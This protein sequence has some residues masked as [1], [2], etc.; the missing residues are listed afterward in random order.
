MHDP[1]AGRNP[2]AGGFF[3]HVKTTLRHIAASA[4]V[5]VLLSAFATGQTPIGTKIDN[6]GTAKFSY[7]GGRNDSAAT[8]VASVTVAGHIGFTL[9]KS[10]SPASAVP[11]DT[12]VYTLVVADTGTAPVGH[13]SVADTLPASLA[14]AGTTA[15]TVSGQVVRWNVPTLAPGGK[16]TL[17]I[18]AALQSNLPAGSVVTNT[19]YG[20]DSTGK[21]VVSQALFAVS[22]LPRLDVRKSVS[23]SSVNGGDTLT[24]LVTLVNSGN[25]TITRVTANDTLPAV[26]VFSSVSPNAS[27]SG[28]V[29]TAAFDS[30]SQGS[31]DTVRITAIVKSNLTG[32][33][34]ILNSARVTS[35]QLPQL[36]GSASS[37]VVPRPAISITKT[38]L[39]DSAKYGDTVR[40][41]ISY[42]NSGNV[43][44]TN[45]T[46]TDS[47]LPG[48]SFLSGSPSG[49]LKN[50]SFLVLRDSL[51][52]GQSDS[53][54][55]STKVVSYKIGGGI[56]RN[57]AT[58][59]SDQTLL[60]SAQAIVTV[61]AV[62]GFMISKSS[63]RDS[64]VI[65]D[66]VRYTIALRNT[67]TIPLT[68]FTMT[69]TLPAMLTDARTVPAGLLNGNFVRFGAD[70]LLP[71]G[72][73]TIMVSARIAFGIPAGSQIV[74]RAWGVAAEAPAKSSEATVTAKASPAA[75]SCRMTLQVNPA[76]VRGDGA[77]TAVITAIYTDSAG[78]PKPDGTLVQFIANGGSF[79]DGRDTSV[80]PLLGGI[81]TDSLKLLVTG[82]MP[83][84]VRITA[85]AADSALCYAAD[86]A[87]AIFYP[88][89][90]AGIVVDHATGQP[91][92]GAIVSVLNPA[93]SVV[94][95]QKTA[96]A[97]S[98]LIP[99]P[100]SGVY[101]VQTVAR[102]QFNQSVAVVD[103]GLTV[104]LSS[105][106]AK[107]PVQAFNSASGR[108]FDGVSGL[109]LPKAGTRVVLTDAQ[110]HAALDSAVTDSTGLFFF[111]KISA[112]SF[113]AV[114][115]DGL[116]R[117]QTA[118]ANAGGGEYVV[119]VNIPL[120]T[121]AAV[122][123]TKTGPAKAYA[124]DT[125]IY[126]IHLAN[127]SRTKLTGVALADTLD[128]SMKYV[129]ATG[130][131]TFDMTGH[132][133]LWSIP[134]VDTMASADFAVTVAF[135]DS[136]PSGTSAINRVVMTGNEIEP[137]F[138]SAVTLVR[139]PARL[140][141]MKVVSVSKAVPGDTLSYLV[142]IV[143]VS[144]IRADSVVLTDKLPAQL[145]YV[146]SVPSASYDAV[147]GTV[148]WILDSLTAGSEI[149]FRVVGRVRSGLPA[150]AYT[151]TNVAQAGWQGG[152]TTSAQNPGSHADV[153]LLVPYLSIQK[154]AV[155]R[156]VE[157]GDAAIYTI[158]VTNISTSTTAYGVVIDDMIPLGCRYIAGSSYRDTVRIADPSGT[159]KLRWNLADSLPGGATITLTYRLV[160]GAGALDGNG[161]N[162]AQGS[163]RTA[164]GIV[165]SSNISQ[166]R[167]QINQGVFTDH[168]LVIGKVFYDDN[169]NREQ[170]PG[171][172]GVKGIELMTEDGTRI[173]TG[174]DGKYSLPDVK[175]GEHVI[176]V[177]KSSLPAGAA[178]MAGYGE[179]AQEPSSRFV[180][181][182]EG[183][184]ARVDF[185][186]RRA[187]P[188]PA[189][190]E[191]RVANIGAVRV[192]R[193]SSPGRII[194]VT[195]EAAAPVRLRGTQF[196]PGKAV[197]KEGAYATLK[198]VGDLAREF[199]RQT[200]AISGHTDSVRIHTREFPSN[201]ELSE[202]RAEAVKR[203]LVQVEKIDSTRISTI[204]FGETAP[205]APN[206]TKNGR[207][208][209]RRVEISMSEPDKE[210]D[211][212]LR[213]VDVSL[214]VHYSGAVPLER[215]ELTDEFDTLLHFVQGSGR[216]GSVPAVPRTEGGKLLWT[217]PA[218]GTSFDAVLSYRLSVTIPSVAEVRA[219]V[220]TRVSVV[221]RTG[222]PIDAGTLATVTVAGRK[223][224]LKPMNFSL[225][226][227]LFEAGSASMKPQAAAALRDAA[228]VLMKYP[229]A[230]VNVDG[231]TDAKPVKN[232]AF[233]SNVALADARAKSV[234]DTLTGRYG[235]AARRISTF[236]WGELK[237][238][239][240]NATEEGR[241]ANRRVEI[242]IYRS[243][244]SADS[245]TV[246]TVDSSAAVEAVV[247]AGDGV[248]S[249]T[250][251]AGEAGKELLVEV[252]VRRSGER[253]PAPGMITDSL[254]PEMTVAASSFHAVRGI[255]SWQ[256]GASVISVKFRQNDSVAVYR[257]KAGVGSGPL[258][259][260]PVHTVTL[261]RMSA[262]GSVF[263][264]RRILSFIKP[265]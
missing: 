222:S 77:A 105:P 6:R 262:S 121:T 13:A 250:C 181:V 97:G 3:N 65:G 22:A 76:V 90:I 202:A 61:N 158:K 62:P 9:K 57:V 106:G 36:A 91:V 4:V 45:V 88:G 150:G 225:P 125:V 132:R 58:I 216:I 204:G 189:A 214:P 120:T 11:G 233:A 240:S 138:A 149:S 207:A 248:L 23:K 104:D 24:Y 203:H 99:V 164:A 231:Y 175:P 35:D 251:I 232:P 83:V 82:A 86:S 159:K 101:A 190:I 184:I 129:G 118:F 111:G 263:V 258:T 100:V 241:A 260:P 178:L 193:I 127:Q 226:G 42:R 139:V 96:A 230:T 107:P 112:G 119:N 220:R 152:M 79:S 147:S 221:P 84:A 161:V 153:D 218:A 244:S 128:P 68:A 56:I 41:V 187:L 243:E 160:V 235:I 223:T 209:N 116:R 242:R 43:T 156:I 249:D 37:T 5:S 69:D 170:D 72:S 177:K 89:A 74:N 212:Y 194:F 131:G 264:N 245:A 50:N 98:Y 247:D 154:Q 55:L 196:D 92:A 265:R 93:D 34:L 148:T 256:A 210:F 53:V 143:N 75:N 51:L 12:V 165:M 2:R 117:G 172:E 144:G 142:S 26:T 38:A 257:Y 188:R 81:A 182:P 173:T 73:D 133:I 94:G 63:A 195:D 228:E 234:A 252:T 44:L 66:T 201:R 70:T 40:Y 237:P 259:V 16:D 171:E 52:P 174:D 80:R 236:G 29:V 115:N 134:A 28:G 95:F 109:A 31:A 163:A 261:T 185:Y 140:S 254:S 33:L 78:H 246:P 71:G 39:A 110:T 176:R 7:F 217:I 135:P 67:G 49:H 208:L 199:P 14:I 198:A 123:L 200:I 21:T 192:R 64:V 85:G 102:D 157:V 166:D 197:L 124:G 239:A 168:G 146:F 183:G 191:Q 10:V 114:V 87:L 15:G 167:I 227:G 255:E 229:D 155:H 54:A 108:L 47:I 20:T 1:G 46:V 17:K 213:Y 253:L 179:F 130:N 215:I 113:L 151:F 211:T 8:N 126:R 32:G 137:V 59:V 103:R 224:R 27:F 169:E 180:Q 30:I 122:T 136:T 48:L 206:G 141:V 186:L 145:A 238:A 60:Q 19:A 25:C 162:T 205:I 219:S 18:S